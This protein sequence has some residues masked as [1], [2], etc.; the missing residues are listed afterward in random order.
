MSYLSTLNHPHDM[1]F[2][3]IGWGNWWAGPSAGIWPTANMIYYF[4]F[5]LPETFTATAGWIM[6]SA[7]G[8]SSAGR[9]GVYSSAGTL[10]G[11]T[12][13]TIDLTTAGG[14]VIRRASF[15]G[16]AALSAGTIYYLAMTVNS[17]GAWTG[18]GCGL[19]SG[20]ADAGDMHGYR[21]EAGSGT[22][23]STATMADYAPATQFAWICGLTQSTTVP[24]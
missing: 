3:T 23:P 18:I 10:L 6:Q 14:N 24:L 21:Q 17:A 19:G 22:L 8:A 2:H 4:P 13:G 9:I 7:A 11:Q 5:S 12:N 15:V 16:D 20:P 1:A